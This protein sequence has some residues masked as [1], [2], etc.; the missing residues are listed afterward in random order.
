MPRGSNNIRVFLRLKPSAT[1]SSLLGYEPGSGEV[2][3]HIP[4]EKKQWLVNNTKTS[5]NFRFDGVLP[6]E[7]DQQQ[8]YDTIASESVE[9]YVLCMH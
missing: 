8:V 5:Y 7:V 2:A 9:R 3:W 1:P 4:V 6:T